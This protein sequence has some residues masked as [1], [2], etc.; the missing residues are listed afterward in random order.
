MH[1]VVDTNV[2]VIANGTDCE[3]ASD[4]CVKQCRIKLGQIERQGIIVVDSGWLILNEYK[5]QV[6]TKFTG[7]VGNR[8]K[9]VGSFFLIWVLTN[10]NNPKHCSQVKITPTL[11]NDG[12]FEE[13]PNDPGLAGFDLSD[14]KF[15]AVACAHPAN[16]PIVNA[17][18][19]DWRDYREPLKQAGVMVEFLC[20]ELL[21]QP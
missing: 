9:D 10:R 3:Q 19:T 17:V 11:N 6:R 15:V 8:S 13:F 1:V 21:S 4:E 18:D 16:P 12:S 2:L 20:P 14:R 7:R 5:G